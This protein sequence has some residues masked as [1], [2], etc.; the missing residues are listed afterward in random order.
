M[1]HIL[2][3]DEGHGGAGKGAESQRAGWASAGGEGSCHG[4]LRVLGS[5]VARPSSWFEPGVRA[6]REL[7]EGTS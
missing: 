6:T 4:G 5:T 7:S 2:A 3:Q 1:G